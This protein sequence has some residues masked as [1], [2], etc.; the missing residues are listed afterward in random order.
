MFSAA[1]NY[2]RQKVIGHCS[3]QTGEANWRSLMVTLTLPMAF[4]GRVSGWSERLLNWLIPVEP[5]NQPRMY[6]RRISQHPVIISNY[7]INKF[8]RPTLAQIFA[9]VEQSGDDV[10]TQ[11]HRPERAVRWVMALT[12]L[13]HEQIKTRSMK[14]FVTFCPVRSVACYSIKCDERRRRWM[15]LKSKNT[16]RPENFNAFDKWTSEPRIS[17]PLFPR[18]AFDDDAC[19][20]LL[21][22]CVFHP[23][24]ACLFVS[25]KKRRLNNFL[26][27]VKYLN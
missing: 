27:V 9:V 14:F 4:A 2:R 26:P 7:S 24:P 10:D 20:Q 12:E 5:I 23:R 13:V 11:S 17:F 25:L 19:L 8:I 1:T 16:E 3:S 21:C 6:G 15:A 22:R 18:H